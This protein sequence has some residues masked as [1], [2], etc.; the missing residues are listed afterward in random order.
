MIPAVLWRVHVG[1]IR[2]FRSASLVEMRADLEN[3][4][5]SPAELVEEA[6]AEV[7]RQASLNAFITVTPERARAHAAAAPKGGAPKSLSGIPVAVKDMFCV[8]GERATAGSRI[9]ENFVPT[10]ESAVTERLWRE[11][12][13]LIGKTNMDE[14]AMGSTTLTSAFGPT[15]NPAAWAGSAPLVPGGSSGGSAAAVAAGIVPAALGTDTGGSVRQPAS[16]CG[17]VGVKPTYGRCSR[18]G[19][20]AYG[21]SFDQAGVFARTVEDSAVLLDGIVGGDSRD[22][23]SLEA[24]PTNF[25][26]A[27][28]L[29]VA[30]MKVGVPRE[31]RVAGLP[32]DVARLWDEAIRTL[33]EAGVQVTDVSLPLSRVALATYYVLVCAE[34]S[35]NLARYDG[36]RYGLRSDARNFD[37]MIEETRARGFGLEVRRRVMAG[38]YVL[39]AG[40]YE[41]FFGRA[42][43]VRALLS[44][45]FSEAMQGLDA[46]LFPTSPIP[47]FPIDSP[48]G[49]GDPVE[50][51]LIDIFTVTANLLGAPAIS[52]PFGTSADGRPLGMQLMGRWLGEESMFALAERLFRER[53]QG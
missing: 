39:S 15:V 38:T 8:A 11:G 1:A 31:F 2:D 33:E 9:L 43:K 52:V 53:R 40:Q 22:A 21:S 37:E 6:L 12:A 35:S 28:G 29:P 46:L 16:M 18:W 14:F 34:A 3:G 26:A 23:T 49:D 36:V 30:A 48:P 4:L 32:Q 50:T 51:Y 41:Q 19:I 42:Q 10:Y 13:C 24:P 25:A 27:V 17:I 45:E 20:I 44:R 47:A 7:K 5:C